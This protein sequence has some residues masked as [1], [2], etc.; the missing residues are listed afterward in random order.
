MTYKLDDKAFS[1]IQQLS[2]VQHGII[3]SYKPQ[4]TD[5]QVYA[6]SISD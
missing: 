3:M 4:M 5:S 1:S 2:T 6:E